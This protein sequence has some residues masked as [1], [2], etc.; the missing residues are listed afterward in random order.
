MVAVVPLQVL[1]G[2]VSPA[3]W[4]VNLT[5]RWAATD[6]IELEGGYGP[7]ARSADHARHHYH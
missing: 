1:R 5:Y 6:D 3:S 7:P 2:S 4:F